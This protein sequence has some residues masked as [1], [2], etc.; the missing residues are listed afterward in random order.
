MFWRTLL[1][2]VSYINV[3]WL[4]SLLFVSERVLMYRIIVFFF[5]AWVDKDNCDKV[6]WVSVLLGV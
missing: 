5:K 1:D 6:V 3:M 2:L 4:Y